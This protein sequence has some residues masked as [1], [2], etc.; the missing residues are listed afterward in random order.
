[1]NAKLRLVISRGAYER[2]PTANDP[3]RALYGWIWVGYFV[4]FGLGATWLF[5]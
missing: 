2:R 3:W 5:R 4:A 1:M